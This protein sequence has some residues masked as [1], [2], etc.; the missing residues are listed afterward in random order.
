MKRPRKIRV[1]KPTRA[2]MKANLLAK[3]EETIEEFLDWVEQTDQPNLTQIEDTVLEFRRHIGQD[4]PKP[5]SKRR[6]TRNRSQAPRVPSAVAK[7][8]TRT[9]K[10]KRSPRG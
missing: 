4:L 3:A 2:E 10:T 9:K 6:P 1:S 8:T 5:R 7:C